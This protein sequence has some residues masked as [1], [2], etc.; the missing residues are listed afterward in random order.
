MHGNL[1][2][3]LQENMVNRPAPETGG[4][5]TISMYTDRKP[6][7]IVCVNR[8]VVVVQMDKVSESVASKN[9]N[10]GMLGRQDWK[11]ERDFEGEIIVF[12]VLK[13]GAIIPYG[14]KSRKQA[15]AQLLVGM[16][17]AYHDWGF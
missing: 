8:D 3:R 10:E 6:C 11:I 9:R 2:N 12:R 14:S 15:G 13:D 17:E 4:G 1:M 5:A 16:H 7:T